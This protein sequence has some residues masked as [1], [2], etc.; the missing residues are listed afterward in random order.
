M[1]RGHRSLKR[2]HGER[3]QFYIEAHHEPIIQK[4]VFDRVQLLMERGLLNSRRKNYSQEERAI[5]EDRS[6][7]E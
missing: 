5:L 3:N 1:D 2:N 6:W 7:R 4:K